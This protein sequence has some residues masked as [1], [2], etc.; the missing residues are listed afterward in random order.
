MPGHI[1]FRERIWC[2]VGEAVQVSGLGRT[3]LFAEIG[4]GKI[5][6]KKEWTKRLIHVES[7]LKRCDPDPEPVANQ[8]A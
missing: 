5:K 1:P 8:T 2:T 7:L 4:A 6:S 3:K